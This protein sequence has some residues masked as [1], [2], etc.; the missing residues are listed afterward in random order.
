MLGTPPGHRVLLRPSILC[1]GLVISKII[2]GRFAAVPPGT[3]TPPGAEVDYHYAGGTQRCL[4]FL[5]EKGFTGRGHAE[6]NL[7]KP[8]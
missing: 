6:T 1:N 3:A 2:P 4:C 5:L 7:D 8:T